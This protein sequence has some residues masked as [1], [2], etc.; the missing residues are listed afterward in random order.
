LYTVLEYNFMKGSVQKAI[1][2]DEIPVRRLCTPPCS[3]VGPVDSVEVLVTRE[4]QPMPASGY[5]TSTSSCVDDSFY[6]L[7]RCAK[8]ALVTGRSAAKGQL[9]AISDQVLTVVRGQATPE[10]HRR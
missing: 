2:I 8:R 4:P 9:G 3:E 10:R 6:V 7:R 5:G 1:Q